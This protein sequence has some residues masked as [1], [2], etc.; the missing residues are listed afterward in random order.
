MSAIREPRRTFLTQ[1]FLCCFYMIL[2]VK[3]AVQAGPIKK[4]YEIEMYR[5]LSKLD[6]LINSQ[7]EIDKKVI[8][9]NLLQETHGMNKADACFVR[10]SVSQLHEIFQLVK[11][12]QHSPHNTYIKNIVGVFNNHIAECMDLIIDDQ[13]IEIPDNCKATHHFS[14]TDLLEKVKELLLKAQ[15]FTKNNDILSDNCEEYFAVCD[16][17]LAGPPHWESTSLVTPVDHFTASQKP[18]SD[19]PSTNHT[20][21]SSMDIIVKSSNSYHDMPTRSLGMPQTTNTSSAPLNWMTKEHTDKNTNLTYTEMGANNSNLNILENKIYTPNASTKPPHTS[22]TAPSHTSAEPPGTNTERL[23]ISTEP[24]NPTT[25]L[26]HIDSDLSLNSSEPPHAGTKT[27]YAGFDL[28]PSS[29]EHP[30][31]DAQHLKDS[32]DPPFSGTS[33]P[34]I[35]RS[36]SP[37][38]QTQLYSTEFPSNKQYL[39]NY[40][41]PPSFD[42]TTVYAN[43]VSPDSITDSASYVK[44]PFTM[45]PDL[46]V[47]VA[48]T[49]DSEL[50]LQSPSDF[51]FDITHRGAY[52]S[53]EDIT[54]NV[55]SG[56]HSSV[57]ITTKMGRS[58]LNTAMET[59]TFV[60]LSSTGSGDFPL[61]KATMTVS[62]DEKNRE[63][64]DSGLGWAANTLGLSPKN[65]VSTKNEL[66]VTS[67]IQSIQ[68]KISLNKEGQLYHHVLQSEIHIMPHER[69]NGVAG[70][71]YASN[72]LPVI[73]TDQ[74]Y[75]KNSEN[76]KD[77]GYLY[78]LISCIVGM[79]LCLSAMLYL[80]HKNRI[81]RR[82]LH[83]TQHDP[84]VPELRPLQTQQ[85]D[86]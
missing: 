38:S 18:Q 31:V 8:E 45:E 68:P 1:V 84:E 76:A 73:E 26:L 79:L 3:S 52:D 41:M 63:L 46:K 47:S 64:E 60:T 54:G 24:P 53:L 75:R 16:I 55:D 12:K 37:H 19:M 80:L 25:E 6:D 30:S 40:M 86:V 48:Q 29:T 69:E 77:R 35:I 72:K 43:L 28:L 85:L 61:N 83:G 36:S 62:S 13:F 71:N 56:L 58:S 15:S 4:C 44:S 22:S 10:G 11:F 67:P 2:L 51:Q 82:Q 7:I 57:S 70:P 50:L 9:V 23:D 21:H 78:S 81:L 74:T 27:L 65:T 14:P 34:H 39:S 32:T 20:S 5:T 33:Q 17:N 66:P 59:Q 49:P 42:E